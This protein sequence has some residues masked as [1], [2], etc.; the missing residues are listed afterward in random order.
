MPIFLLNIALVVVFFIMAESS[1][2]QQQCGTKKV[3]FARPP[4][5]QRNFVSSAVESGCRAHSQ[6]LSLKT[7]KLLKNFSLSLPEIVSI[8]KQLR[9]KELAELFENCFPNTLDTTVSFYNPLTFV[10]TG[11]LE[12]EVRASE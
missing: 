3:P 12:G 6:L 9:D 1:N 8:S 7:Y 2:A 4:S 5:S 11:D 10:I